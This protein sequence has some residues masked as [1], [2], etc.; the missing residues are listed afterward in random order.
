MLFQRNT[1]CWNVEKAMVTQHDIILSSRFLSYSRTPFV[2]WWRRRSRS[3]FYLGPKIPRRGWRVMTCQPL[4][5]GNPT[6]KGIIWSGVSN[7]LDLSVRGSNTSLTN[8]SLEYFSGRERP[9]L[10]K[11][12][13]TN[14][15]LMTA[16]TPRFPRSALTL[17]CLPLRVGWQALRRP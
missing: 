16:G 8:T 13:Q 2:G 3:F 4:G 10:A 7:R 6:P 17:L 14:M 9:T 1:S 5:K 11:V 15:T 12:C